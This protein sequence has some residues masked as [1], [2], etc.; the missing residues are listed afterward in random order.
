MFLIIANLKFIG[1]QPTIQQ[2]D[3]ITLAGPQSPP[4]LQSVTALAS[5]ISTAW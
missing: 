1:K 5:T 3:S 4:Q 2:P